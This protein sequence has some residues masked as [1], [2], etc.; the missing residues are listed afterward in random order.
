MGC[1]WAEG[2]WPGKRALDF[3]RTSDRVLVDIPG[4]FRAL[5][6]MTWVRVDYFDNRLNALLLSDGWSSRK[7]HW[8]LDGRGV[9]VFAVKGSFECYSP[10]VLGEDRLGL[11]TH[12][13]AAFDAGRGELAT[14]VNGREVRRV[15]IPGS[16]RAILGGATIGNYTDPPSTEPSDRIIRN[17]NGRIDEFLVFDR[18][19]DA[20]EVE[21]IYEA[22][23][24]S[25]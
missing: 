6:L 19:L 9:L 7:L 25:P 4:E 23:R 16:S 11:W 17:L 21:A 10:V 2:R 18:G 20:R 13:A 12:L 1:E 8:E 22:G 24:P 14:Y 15:A 5:T 3:K